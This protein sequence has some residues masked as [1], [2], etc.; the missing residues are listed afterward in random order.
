MRVPGPGLNGMDDPFL[1]AG[2]VAFVVVAVATPG[3]LQFLLATLGAQGA[4]RAGGAILA[5]GALSYAA[6]Y[7]T[8]GAGARRL[9]ETYPGV[10]SAFQIAGA[11]LM[12]WLAWRIATAPM[13]AGRGMS[14]RGFVQGFGISALNPRA[15]AGAMTVG[16]AFC[17]PNADVFDHAVT[18]GG[19]ALAAMV[20]ICGAWLVGGT[21]LE[22][23]LARPAVFRAFSVSAA[24]VLVL[25][26]ARTF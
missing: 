13:G 10:F 16:V 26:V 12:V 23:V 19:V 2:L 15:W 24:A 5:G 21:L 4:A 20:A 22:R 3:P 1:P 18:F 7:A 14:R 6:I 17:D 9:A 25:S 8:G 11:V